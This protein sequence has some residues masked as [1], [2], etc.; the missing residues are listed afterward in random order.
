VAL[1]R[2]TGNYG[3]MAKALRLY[4]KEIRVTS[5]ISALITLIA[6]SMIVPMILLII[7][8]VQVQRPLARQDLSR[9]PANLPIQDG[10]VTRGRFLSL[11]IK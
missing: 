1:G 3:S 6:I 2:S 9:D 8:P 7:L 11:L 4:T 10:T 5:V